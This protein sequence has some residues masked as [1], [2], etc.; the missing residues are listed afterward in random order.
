MPY[1]KKSVAKGSG[2]KGKGGKK[3]SNVKKGVVTPG[4]KA[5]SWQ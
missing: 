4:K 3:A 5:G 2:L 1:G